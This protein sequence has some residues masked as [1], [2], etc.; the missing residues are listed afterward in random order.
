[1]DGGSD[2]T[3]SYV[4]AG[5]IF[6]PIKVPNAGLTSAHAINDSGEVAGLYVDTK[7]Q[8]SGFIES[9][10]KY[11]TLPPSYRA[12]SINNAGQVVGWYVDSTG[13]AHGFVENGANFTTGSPG[14]FTTLDAPGATDTI[15][16]GINDA[17][18]VVG[19][20]ATSL[21]IF[22]GFIESGGN[23]ATGTAG[24]FITIDPT[25][26]TST[27]L[28]GINSVGEVIGYYGDSTGGHAFTASALPLTVVSIQATNPVVHVGL[29]GDLEDINF[30][31]TRSGS[32][33]SPITLNYA[34]TGIASDDYHLTSLVG[35]ITIP[36]GAKSAD[37]V[38]RFTSID[39][40]P[41]PTEDLQVT[42]V[43]SSASPDV[44][45]SQPVATVSIEN[46]NGPYTADHL[47]GWAEQRAAVQW[48]ADHPGGQVTLDDFVKIADNAR[49]FLRAERGE[50]GRSTDTILRDA[51]YYLFGF[52]SAISLKPFF[53]G[54]A[55]I[56]GPYN[57]VKY[58]VQQAGLNDSFLR[59]DQY[60]PN[61][62]AG[63][64]LQVYSGLL[65]GGSLVWGEGRVD[66][67]ALTKSWAAGNLA[68]PTETM[69]GEADEG[70]LAGSTVFADTSGDGLFDYSKPFGFTDPNG[71]FAIAASSAPLIAFG[72][73]DISTGLPFKGQLSAPAGASVITPLTTLLTHLS[74]PSAQQKVLS[75]LGLSSSLNLTTL[76]PIA[77]A[78]AGNA[79]GAAPVVAGAKVYDTV[80]LIASAVR[81]AGGNVTTSSQSAIAAI[82][83]AIGGAGINLTN[84]ADVSALIKALGQSENLLLG[85]GAVDSLA[86]IIVASNTALDAKLQ[87]DGSGTA[88]LNDVAAVEKVIQGTAANAVE[89]AGND[90]TQ[91]QSLASAF[92]G[93]NLDAAVATALNHLGPTGDTTA[94]IFTPVTDQTLEATS[95]AG[96]VAMFSTTATDTVD[97]TDPVVFKEGNTVV[98]SGDAFALGTHT[99]TAST[100][101]AVGNLASE[102]FRITVVDTIA[103][104]LTSVA[105]A[106]VH[107]TS[108]NGASAVFAATASDL[109]DGNGVVVFKEGNNVVHSGDVFAVGTHMIIA[110]ATDAAGNTASE[111][112]A[113]NIVD[114][115]PVLVHQTGAQAATTGAAFS[116]ALSPDTF[117]DPDAGDHLSMTAAQ[118]NGQPLPHWLT[119]DPT[120]ETLNGI[121]AAADAGNLDI[122]I[123]AT[124]PAGLFAVDSFQFTVSPGA[125]PDNAPVITSDGAGPT[126]SI[127]ITDDT[128]YVDTIQASDPDPNAKISYSI[129]GGRDQKLF[130]IDSTSGALSFKSMPRDS[131]TYVIK[132]AASDGS[133]Q[134]T[135]TIDVEVGNGA[136]ERGNAKVADTFVFKPGF[137]LA[138]VSNFDANS[139][140]HDVLELD[141]TLFCGA[142]AHEPAGA[143]HNLLEH[144]SF[145]VGHD[146]IIATDTHDLID[147][148]NTNLHALL[149]DV[150]LT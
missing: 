40:M 82:A 53:I 128:K 2:L 45:I 146:V 50:P 16:V 26:S 114:G 41:R 22:H 64:S 60:N 118:S 99:I 27:M 10:D 129:I 113:I 49:G 57:I 105:D 81:A 96:A 33:S 103:P 7:G 13:H 23:Y 104:E 97:G 61:A 123:K 139:P 80:A 110:T 20:Y 143:R 71:N 17:G 95:A 78:Q 126:A 149:N 25:G 12:L 135:Q 46:D 36:A 51:E 39:D 125:T 127:I 3:V 24:T 31:V 83:T 30:E 86:A 93:A 85:Q 9:G 106:S 136:F 121:P 37:L 44:Q 18:Q 67:S 54:G 91:L 101:D 87:A 88:L 73:T 34:I 47:I 137:G 74:D 141:H 134:D 90:P 48:L 19:N 62:P 130:T 120:T 35:S 147:V 8:T 6:T 132:V 70:Y 107:A 29:A 21:G 77:E 11:I 52:T 112:F 58:L 32:S 4:Y 102:T 55:A 150:L 115:A 92:T 109:V 100:I 38:L 43:R 108:P 133:L 14:T 59:V 63:G 42:V 119:F 65:Q 145:Q 138:I 79:D 116:Y 15:P 144:H 72:G 5:G 94:P 98:H 84:K 124:D 1:L 148:R 75:A 66:F 111:S 69:N 76:D 140:T 122:S 142:D 117:Q 131:H 56:A 28:T 89:Q 68:A